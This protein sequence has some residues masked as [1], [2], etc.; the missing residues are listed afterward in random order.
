MTK[1][2]W[3]IALLSLLLLSSALFLFLPQQ[4]LPRMVDF[5]VNYKA[6]HRLLWGETLYR[7]EDGHYQFKYPPFAAFIYLPLNLLPLSIAKFLW[8]Y[9]S[10][11]A[12]TIILFLASRLATA[13]QP[14]PYYVPLS[15]G[16]ILAR[17]FL[18]E[19]S[20]GQ[21]N[22]L[23]TCL[24]L[25]MVGSWPD[26]MKPFKYH[27]R[28][29]FFWGLATALKPYALIFLPLFILRRAWKIIIIGLILLL[30]GFLAPMLFYGPQGNWQVHQEWLIRL[31]QSTPPLLTTLDNVSIFGLLAKWGSP[32]FPVWLVGLIIIGILALVM[33]LVVLYSRQIKQPI[34][35]EAFLLL[36]LIPLVSP[37]GWDYT[38]LSAAPA[39]AL[40]VNC[41]S[42]FPRWDRYFLVFVLASVGLTFY[43]LLGRKLYTTLMAAS[44]P[45][46]LFLLLFL[47]LLWLRLKKIA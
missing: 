34:K 29:A 35:L 19:L 15:T 3:I 47:H 17:F 24:L 8:F 5:E 11:I 26:K 9:V 18:R 10:T 6:G 33:F 27:F 36:I 2:Q 42:H 20:L 12:I 45:T 22:A 44:L 1:R 14:L 21:I 43:D 23:I 16:L 25:L 13:K 41:L 38:F 37:L 46:L 4:I 31:S 28:T 32:P 7:P 40:L 39:I 30:L